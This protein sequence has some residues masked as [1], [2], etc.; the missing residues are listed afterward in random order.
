MDEQMN[1]EELQQEIATLESDIETISAELEDVRAQLSPEGS[2]QPEGEQQAEDAMNGTEEEPDE[3]KATLIAKEQ[4]LAQELVTKQMKLVALHK[5]LND[6]NSN[7]G[8][9]N[10]I[11]EE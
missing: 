6:I 4:E 8:M 1:K 9:Q 11:E 10:F 2:E 7:E 5:K 3:E